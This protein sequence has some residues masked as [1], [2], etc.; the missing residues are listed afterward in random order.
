MKEKN[1]KIMKKKGNRKRETDTKIKT[2]KRKI[3]RVKEKDSE[4]KGENRLWRKEIPKE[5][6]K[7]SRRIDR[8][9]RKGVK[10]RKRVKKKKIDR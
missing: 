10:W 7:D 2:W 3:E 9:M 4:W 6:E 1:E 5:K 8:K